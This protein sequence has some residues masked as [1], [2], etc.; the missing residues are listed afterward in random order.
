MLQNGRNNI[1]REKKTSNKGRQ[2]F[3][4]VTVL[5][6][7]EQLYYWTVSRERKGIV[8]VI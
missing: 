8:S 3:F 5:T 1:F 7:S 6:E 2:T 4:D